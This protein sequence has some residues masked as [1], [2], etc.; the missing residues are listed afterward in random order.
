[1][2]MACEPMMRKRL[3][4]QVSVSSHADTHDDDRILGR[5]ENIVLPLC[6]GQTISP[7][8]L[9]EK[10]PEANLLIM[11]IELSEVEQIISI[12]RRDYE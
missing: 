4:L 8:K 7:P 12:R 5:I 2:A 11:Y 6:L 1:M 10:K 3:R 9:Q